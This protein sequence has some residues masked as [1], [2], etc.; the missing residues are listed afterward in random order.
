MCHIPPNSLNRN[1]IPSYKFTIQALLYSCNF[2]KD[3][4]LLCKHVIVNKHMQIIAYTI[5]VIQGLVIN[6]CL[7][8]TFKENVLLKG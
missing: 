2:F 4:A 1:T 3:A 5:L 6:W 8:E 7:H